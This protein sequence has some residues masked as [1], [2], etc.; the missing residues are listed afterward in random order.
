MLSSVILPFSIYAIPCFAGIALIPLAVEIGVATAVI[1]YFAVSFLSLMLVPN[2]ETSLMFVAFFGY[3]PLLRMKMYKIKYRLV[4]LIIKFAVFNTAMIVGYYLL[5]NVFGLYY[6]MDEL[7][8]GFGY[9]LLGV[10]N[11]GFALYDFALLSLMRVY[12]HRV[13]KLI[14]KGK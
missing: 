1:A 10:G 11:I 14:F 12:I 2:L 7:A 4:R 3:Y 8:D 9:V 6:L 5:I 13:R